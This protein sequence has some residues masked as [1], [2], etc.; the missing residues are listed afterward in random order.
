MPRPDNNRKAGI[1]DR[2]HWL[3]RPRVWIP[4]LLGVASLFVWGLIF[5]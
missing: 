4:V 2:P 3:A 5:R 1:Y